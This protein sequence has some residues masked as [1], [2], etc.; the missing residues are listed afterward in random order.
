MTVSTRREK[1]QWKSD[2]RTIFA[3]LFFTKLRR[4]K[5][6]PAPPPPPHTH[7]HTHTFVYLRFIWKWLTQ[8]K[9]SLVSVHNLLKNNKQTK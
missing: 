8:S 7:T 3:S 9:K 2:L 4:M 5:W 1:E 6:Y